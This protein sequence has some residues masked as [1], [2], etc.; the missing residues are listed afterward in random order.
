MNSVVLNSVKA[1]NSTLEIDFACNGRMKKFFKDRKFVA[2]YNVC[3]ETTPPSILVIPFLAIACPVVWADNAEVYVDE[4]DETFLQSL[5]AVKKT[6]RKF[7]PQMNFSGRIHVKKVVKASNRN[8]FRKML[9]Y[10]GGI[11]SLATLIRHQSEKPILFTVFEKGFAPAFIVDIAKDVSKECGL[12][13]RTVKNNPYGTLDIPMLATYRNKINGDWYQR[14]MHGLALIGLS[15]PIA[16]MENVKTIYIAA[17]ATKELLQPWGSHPEIDSNVAWDG[18]NAIHDGFELS[19]QKKICLISEYIKKYHHQLKVRSCNFP[20]IVQNC[21]VCE[22]C[23]R[24]IV[25]LELAGINSMECGFMLREYTFPT[26]KENL[27][28]GKW[29]FGGNEDWLWKDILSQY[30]HNMN[31]P[32]PKLN[33]FLE[34]LSTIDFQIIKSSTS[35]NS[36]KIKLL[37]WKMIIPIIMYYPYFCHVIFR[38][39]YKNFEAFLHI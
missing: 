25:G 7:Y 35:G 18:T 26:I 19:R 27:L 31:L 21:S 17:S 2:E 16:Y 14:V 23:S 11:D 12:E 15:A 13:L 1:K 39:F 33:S 34:W 28:R 5:G 38:K 36:S 32:N 30:S 4:C 20:T 37:V 22:K 9:L 24:T 29:N 8:S 3:I 10:S 6:L